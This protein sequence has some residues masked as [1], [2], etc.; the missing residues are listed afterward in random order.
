MSLYNLDLVKQHDLNTFCCAKCRAFICSSRSSPGF[1]NHSSYG[2]LNIGLAHSYSKTKDIEAIDILWSKSKVSYTFVPSLIRGRWEKNCYN[3][4]F[5]GISV[6]NGGISIDKVSL[7]S[8]LKQVS[9]LMLK[10][11]DNR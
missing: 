1:I 11:Y 6:A 3:L 7:K 10:S 8:I 2:L 5:S 4:P 9:Q